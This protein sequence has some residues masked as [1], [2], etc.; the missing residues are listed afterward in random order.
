MDFSDGLGGHSA[1]LASSELSVKENMM[2]QWT[3]KSAG[4]KTVAAIADGLVA[5]A[6]GNAVVNGAARRL[7]KPCFHACI[8]C[9]RSW[10][11]EVT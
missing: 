7:G 9:G 3:P 8:G 6:I 11:A 10:V 2:W 5:A 4:G 1:M